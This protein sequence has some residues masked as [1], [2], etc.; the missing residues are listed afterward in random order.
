MSAPQGEQAEATVAER[1]QKP[2]D[3]WTSEP[4]FPLGSAKIDARLCT[5][6]DLLEL[7]SLETESSRWWWWE[8]EPSKAKLTFPLKLATHTL[9]SFQGFTFPFECDFINIFREQFV[10]Q[11]PMIWYRNE[12]NF[13]FS[14]LSFWVSQVVLVKKNLLANMQ[15]KQ[16]RSRVGKIPWR[17]AWRP[18]PVFLLGESYRQRSLV[19]YSPWGHK[20]S[21]MTEAT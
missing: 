8:G 5:P 16:V 20:E 13:P 11:R 9:L 17:R 10:I 3:R 12:T 18:T 1:D 4:S 15:E 19:G 7:S 14:S 21:D 2:W 6:P